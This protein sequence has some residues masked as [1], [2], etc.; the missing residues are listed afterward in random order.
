M[1]NAKCK[2]GHTIGHMVPSW[3]SYSGGTGD[4]V[5]ETQF[6]PCYC[7]P[8]VNKPRA[9]LCVTVCDINPRDNK[10]F[11]NWNSRFVGKWSNLGTVLLFRACAPRRPCPDLYSHCPFMLFF[12]SLGLLNVSLTTHPLMSGC[13]LSIL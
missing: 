2:R 7:H 11:Q 13:S 5:W 3:C 12:C 9:A 8:R 1:A 10:C 6:R 4:Q